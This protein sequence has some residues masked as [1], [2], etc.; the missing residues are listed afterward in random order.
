MISLAEKIARFV[1]S[2]TSI[3]LHTIVFLIFLILILLGYNA[4]QLLLTLTTL[5]SLEA[6]YLSIFI[7]MAVNKNTEDLHEIEEDIEDVEEELDEI[8]K[9]I[10]TD[11]KQSTSEQLSN[12]EK[13]KEINAML[14]TILTELQN[15]R[16]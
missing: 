8:S 2:V 11:L 5:V 6:I 7:Q 3:I 9:D 1:G 4:E 13:F 15:P 12:E 10:D 14:Q 16:R